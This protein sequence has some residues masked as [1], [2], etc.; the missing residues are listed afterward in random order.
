MGTYHATQIYFSPS[1]TTE[2]V[3]RCFT[4]A[5]EQNADAIDLLR[6]PLRET[7]AFGDSD[8]AVVAVPVFSG[9]IP[10]FCQE[11]LENLKGDGTP[12]VAL[13]VYGNRDYDD[14]LLELYNLL[15]ERGFVVIGA[16]AFLAQHSL[17]T[18]VAQNRPDASDTAKIEAF[19]AQCK[20]KLEEGDISPVKAQIK[21][22][23]PYKDY[24]TGGFKPYGDDTC[25]KCNACVKICP[26]DAISA[27]DP[28]KTDE[29]KCISCTACIANCPKHSRAFCGEAYEGMHI[30]FAEMNAQRKEPEIFF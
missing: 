26:A 30:K 5:I 27:D 17:F 25:I 9:R 28:R 24:P 18:N 6:K 20:A 1:G 11:M 21:G 16:A 14:A 10:R 8:L 12:A 29:A 13:A 19:A 2:K 7:R 15:S 23:K 4:G 3:A 22:N